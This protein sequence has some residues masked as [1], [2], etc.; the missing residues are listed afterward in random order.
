M[1]API[2]YYDL[3]KTAQKRQEQS[4]RYTASLRVNMSRVESSY[5]ESKAE[6]MALVPG[7]NESNE[8]FKGLMY[9]KVEGN[10]HF[11]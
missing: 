11:E 6:V 1:T 9:Y 10:L 8:H 3:Y 5:H 2:Q 7:F 4:D